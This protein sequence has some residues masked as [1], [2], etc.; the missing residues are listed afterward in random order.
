MEEYL[1]LLKMVPLFWDIEEQEL[2][3]LLKCLNAKVNDYKADSIIFC[4]GDVAQYVGIVISGEVQIVKDD[5]YGN[6]SIVAYSQ[7][8]QLF[9]EAFACADVRILPVSILTTSDSKVMLV[10]YRKVI[11]MCT[12]GCSFHN[13]LIYNMLKIVAN[14]NVMLNQ[15]IEFT[16]KRSTREK[17]MA[18]L[19]YEAKTAENNTFIIPFNRQELADY[20]CVDRSAMSNELSKLRKEGTLEFHKNKFRL[21]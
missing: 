7:S 11:T 8:G 9:A 20:L 17:L 15:K 2:H 21:I 19:A 12:G 16:S 6:R 1:S 13:R 4:E 14:K 10:D 18:Y 3:N 5:Y